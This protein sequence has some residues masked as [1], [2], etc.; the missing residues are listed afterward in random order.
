[1]SPAVRGVVA[2]ILGLLLAFAI[3]FAVDAV[4]AKIYPPPPGV[5]LADPESVKAMMAV[6][7]RAALV[8]V[9]AGWFVSALLGTAV[10]ARFARP[11]GWPP[12]TVGILLLAAAV[13]NMYVIP[14]PVWFW[15]VGVATYPVATGLGARL[16]GTPVK[17]RGQ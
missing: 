1:M 8:V 12:L 2:V 3:A 16:G 10:A 5:D 6:M 7:P 4:N 11:A 15:V 9:L 17:P 13:M 14:H